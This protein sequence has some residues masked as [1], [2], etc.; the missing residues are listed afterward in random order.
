LDAAEQ[1]DTQSVRRYV[2]LFGQ[3]E[4]RAGDGDAGERGE[5]GAVVTQFES[6]RAGCVAS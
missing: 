4:L 1:Q 5:A 3:L 6:I 2:R